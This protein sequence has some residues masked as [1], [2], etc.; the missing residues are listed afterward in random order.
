MAIPTS[1]TSGGV[2]L[3]RAGFR[4]AAFPTDPT[5]WM[6]VQA[7]SSTA[8]ASSRTRIQKFTP[9]GGNQVV[10]TF[11]VPYSTKTYFTRARSFAIGYTTSPWTTVAS[12]KPYYLVNR[13]PDPG[14]YAHHVSQFGTLTSARNKSL[15]I[16]ASLFQP[17]Q[18]TQKWTLSEAA[19]QPNTTATTQSAFVNLALPV[20][21]TLTKVTWTG[22]R[23]ASASKFVGRV[24][25]VFTTANG[26]NVNSVILT[27]N[28]L[29][30]GTGSRT[31]A[32]SAMAEVV[33][34]TKG[35]SLQISLHTTSV[36]MTNGAS[37]NWVDVTYTMPNIGAAY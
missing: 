16:T 36:V 5:F 18:T 6:E 22:V 19:L 37:L 3:R 4:V 31:V 28:T 25:R 30:T 17:S 23:R 8:F 10:A 7:S 9:S 24:R 11:E 14:H 1:M 29:T 35:L 26:G 12:G 20:G 27:T 32:S 13:M 33:T 21:V 2:T 34:S 15:R